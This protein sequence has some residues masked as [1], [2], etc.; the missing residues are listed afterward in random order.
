MLNL[1]KLTLLCCLV[2]AI[3]FSSSSLLAQDDETLIHVDVLPYFPGCEEFAKDPEAK[4]TCSNN[5]LVKFISTT[6]KYPE[7]AKAQG[8]AGTVIVSFVVKK[9]GSI[10]DAFILKDIGGGCGEQ[11]LA[12]IAQMPLWKAGINKNQKVNV[13][14]NLPIK[15]SF[16]GQGTTSKYRLL[17]GEIKGKTITRKE[18]KKNLL[19]SIAIRG[20]YGEN[21]QATEVIVA[22]ERKKKF[23]DAVG[24]NKMDDAQRWV[25][26]KARNG[27]II[28]FSASIQED[29]KFIEVDREFMVVKKKQE[30]VVLAIPSVKEQEEAKKEQ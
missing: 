17:W 2:I 12:V 4:R 7:E 14:L 11:A 20:P 5:N 29:G 28:T 23:L 10:K 21:I 13:K 8:I 30:K 24:Q 3:L 16:S 19:N 26:K 22:Y 15:F 6:L 25:L 1:N 18:I 27:G 9:D